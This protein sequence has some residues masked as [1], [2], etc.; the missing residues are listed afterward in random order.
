MPPIGLLLSGVDF[1]QLAWVLKAD[2]PLRPRPTNWWR[3][4]TALF[5]NA[6]IQFL[7]VAWVVFMLVKVVNA[8]RRTEAEPPAEE[9]PP[10]RRRRKPC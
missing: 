10:R 5:I 6:I 9:A 7:I 8:M 1:S 2:D 4:S 3:S